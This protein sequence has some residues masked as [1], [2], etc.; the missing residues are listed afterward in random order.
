MGISNQELAAAL[1]GIHAQRLVRVNCIACNRAY[2]SEEALIQIKGST[3][4]AWMKGA[5]CAACGFTGV[6]GRRA[7]H[8]ILPITAPIRE[9]IAAGA[10]LGEIESLARR[11]GKSSLFDH[12][13]ALA[14]QGIIALEEAVRVT[15]PEV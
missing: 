13:L 7:I 4:G 3:Q 11:Q 8:E 9:L 1:L 6:K 2:A 12:A 10:Q 14:R 5:G 15:V